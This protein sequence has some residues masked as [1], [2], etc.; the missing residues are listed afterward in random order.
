MKKALLAA[1][2]ACE[3]ILEGG[4]PPAVRPDIVINLGTAA[5]R[6]SP[7]SKVLDRTREEWLKIT[8]GKVLMRIYPAGVRGDEAGMI[9]KTRIGELQA[10]GLS[11]VGLALVEPAVGCLQIPLLIDSYEEF[12]YVRDRIGPRLEALI[13]KRGFVL[14]QWSDVGWVHFFTRKPARTPQDLRKLKLFTSAGDPEAEK[15]YKK[16][17]LNVVPLAVTDLQIS[18]RTNVIQAFDVPPLFALLDQ[19]FGLAKNMIDLKWAPLA[20]ATLVSKTA[21]DRI[22]EAKRAEMSRAARAAAL[23]SREEIRKLGDDAVSVM[24]KKGLTVVSLDAAA[25]RQWQSEVEAAYPK[26]RGSLV[27]AD[28]FDEVVRLHEEFRSQAEKAA[29]KKVEKTDSE[30][31]E[32]AGSKKAEKAGS[33]KAGKSGSR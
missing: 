14:L 20:G 16:F 33:R 17:G 19:S 3:F 13:E 27:P 22:P 32:K 11:G 21:W 23:R 28:L 24:R 6:D 7:W 2:M 9:L 31:A 15:L 25:R 30:K 29:S 12:D 4:A 10:V 18:L 26:L 5:P 8:G 1:V